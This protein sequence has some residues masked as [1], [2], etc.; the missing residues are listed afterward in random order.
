MCDSRGQFPNGCQ[1]LGV[2]HLLFELLFVGDI[3]G[4]P[5]H[6]QYPAGVITERRT[7]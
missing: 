2:Q 5:Q 4:D 6:P 1:F 3:A 7:R